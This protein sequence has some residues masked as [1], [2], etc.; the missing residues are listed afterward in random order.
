MIRAVIDTNV[1]V[2]GTVGLNRP[3][4]IPGEILRKW[5][6]GLF[7]QI[8]SDPIIS[9]VRR[10][11]NEPYFAV[12][13]SELDRILAVDALITYG[14]HVALPSSVEAVS[15]HPEDDL[16]LATALQGGADAIVTGDKQLLKLGHFHGIAIVNAAAF[17]SQLSESQ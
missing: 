5:H 12:R 17:V 9:E 7:V 8:T 3:D 10:T 2:S 13:I 16:I 14:Q 15:T 1:F 11:L 6:R 4:S